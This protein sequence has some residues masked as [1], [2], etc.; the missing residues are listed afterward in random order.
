MAVS[1][2]DIAVGKCYVTPTGQVRRVLK[3]EAATVE[4]EARGSRAV[5]RDV[6]GPGTPVAI[7]K[8]VAAVDREVRC[9]YDPN[10]PEHEP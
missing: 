9:N 8:F 5:P 3:I 7:D 6:W 4:Y 1:P 10:Y 2:G